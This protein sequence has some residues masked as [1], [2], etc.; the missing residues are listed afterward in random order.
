MMGK[1]QKCRNIEDISDLL[2][3][4][5]GKNWE[6]FYEINLNRKKYT[7]YSR[8]FWRSTSKQEAKT[9]EQI[10]MNV[11]LVEKNFKEP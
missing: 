7:T 1:V 4:H 2:D 10:Q 6:E 3:L 8:S 11:I 9:D 5:F